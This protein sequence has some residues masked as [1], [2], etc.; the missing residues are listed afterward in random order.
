M[1]NPL[2]VELAPSAAR[3]SN[4]SGTAIDIGAL[5]T[6]AQLELL[7][8][9]LS[10]GADALLQ[11]TVETS[12]QSGSGYRSVGTF[13]A[14][15]S[16]GQTKVEA[17]F[18]DLDR[19]LRVSWSVAGAAASFTFQVVG[20]A[21]VLY[22]EPRHVRKLGIQQ[23]ALKKVSDND[24]AEHCISASV[25]SDGHLKGGFTLPLSAWGIDLRLYNARIAVYN[26]LQATGWSPIGP[27]DS[28]LLAYKNAL[29]WLKG[30]SNGAIDPPDIVD[31]TPTVE[32][33]SFAV[34][35][36]TPRC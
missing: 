32:E 10:G 14:V 2:A 22:A 21:H 8:S 18:A 13:P 36:G 17:C 30:V 7:V 26:F 11:V 28:I 20:H 27:E 35:S 25:E 31:A 4:A 1:A 19:Y 3:T 9:A 15:T 24:L 5:R 29:A 6:A 12:E 16:V 33:R 23:G 34:V